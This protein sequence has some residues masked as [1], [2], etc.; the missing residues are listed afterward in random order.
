MTK[1]RLIAYIHNFIFHEDHSGKLIKKGAKYHQ[2][3]GIRF[4]V[5]ATSKAIKP[6]G[7]GRIGV[8]WHTQGSGK[9]MSMA[10]YTG[11]LRQL[12]ALRNP[13][14]V[15][16]VDRNDLDNQLYGNFVLAKDV[17]G[18][19]EHAE[20]TDELRL[21]LDREAGGVIFTTIEKF[22]VKKSKKTLLQQINSLL[23]EG[24]GGVIS[25]KGHTPNPS[26]EGNSAVDRKGNSQEGNNAVDSDINSTND[27]GTLTIFPLKEGKGGVMS[28]G[29]TP[30]P[31]PRGGMWSGQKRQF[32]RRE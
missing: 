8:I 13:T 30:D 28:Q 18:H 31:S 15:M 7:D 23:E 27:Q 25:Q 29:H 19:V 12:P 5:E 1:D 22:R 10:I 6:M 2:F 11:I 32:S 20:S 3:F 4:A 24:K 9:S 14:I 16:Q 17:V 26:Q 21:L